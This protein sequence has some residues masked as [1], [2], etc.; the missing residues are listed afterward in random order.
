MASSYGPWVAS[1]DWRVWVGVTSTSST[2]T[3]ATIQV[4]GWF[5][6]DQGSSIGDGNVQGWVGY[7]I[8][9][10]TV[11]WDPSGSTGVAIDPFSAGS[12]K[13]YRTKSWTINKT[14]SAQT[15]TGYAYVSGEVSGT[16][17]YGKVSQAAA[18]ITI[19]AKTSKTISYN[20]NGGSGAPAAQTK[21]YGETLT[22]SSTRPTRTNYNFKGW[23]TS[24]TATTAAKQPGD[25]YT[26]DPS[27]NVVFYAVWELAYVAPTLNISAYRSDSNGN[28]SDTATDYITIKYSWSLNQTGGTN[29]SGTITPKI[30]TSTKTAI[31]I[32]GQTGSGTTSAYSCS[33]PATSTMTVSVTLKDAHNLTT[34]RTVTVGR[35]FKPFTMAN[36][37]AAAAFFGIASASWDKILKIFG[38]LFIEGA[39]AALRF[40]STASTTKIGKNVPSSNVTL[41][42]ELV[43]DS[44]DTNVYYSQVVRNS[45]DHLY[46]SYVLRRLNAAG[47][48][49]TG[50]FYT[51]LTKDG[52]STLTFTG[53]NTKKN[54][55]KA[56]SGWTSIATASGTTAKTFS[57]VS[58]AGYSELLVVCKYSTTYRSSVVVPVAEL[59]TTERWW[60]L[61]GGWWSTGYGAA[62]KLTKTKIAPDKIMVGSSSVNADWTV[63][64]R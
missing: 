64:A 9:S 18:S 57:D 17:Y 29:T 37:G 58:T 49:I 25:N 47:T 46:K 38:S 33:I 11:T 50:G 13:Y 12:S 39:N 36:G 48:A 62:C 30:G 15:I 55:H 10:G 14:H 32:S 26:D 42:S 56:I 52:E 5:Q 43:Y 7:K 41:Q 22:L 59:D 51:Y 19:P 54:W 34:T 23:A 27:N 45:S 35:V 28:R 3:Q 2:D 53:T 16:T 31:S 8:G 1:D 60:Y 21:W 20:A 44:D 61:G 6:S 4:Q 24:S 63:Y 40:Q